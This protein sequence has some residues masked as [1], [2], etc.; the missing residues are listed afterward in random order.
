MEADSSFAMTGF[1]V[2]RKSNNLGRGLFRQMAGRRLIPLPVEIPVCHRPA[3]RA[4]KLQN[5]L[6]MDW[7]IGVARIVRR[8][9]PD[10][11]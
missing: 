9:G 4:G 8:Q 10:A 1:P 2:F 7:M 3:E 6:V 5:L 11:P